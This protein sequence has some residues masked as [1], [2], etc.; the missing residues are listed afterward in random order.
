M[1]GPGTGPPP[2][3]VAP[4]EV[5]PPER[6][7]QPLHG[8]LRIGA[9]PAAS[10]RRPCGR[11]AAGRRAPPAPSAPRAGRLPPSPRRVLA[12]QVVPRAARAHL[13]VEAHH[14]I[15]PASQALE[16]GGGPRA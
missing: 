2:E 8:A 4:L 16:L 13:D 10:G 3:S 11:R 5:P 1:S 7:A 9:S 15:G 12:K 6:A 14:R